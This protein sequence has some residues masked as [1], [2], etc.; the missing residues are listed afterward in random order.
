MSDDDLNSVKVDSSKVMTV[1]K[2][3]DTASIDPCLLQLRLLP[4]A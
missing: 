1:E 4:R 3:V 2:F